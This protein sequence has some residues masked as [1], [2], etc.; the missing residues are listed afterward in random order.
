MMLSEK[1]KEMV[2][3]QDWCYVELPQS[4]TDALQSIGIDL[5]T[6][7][8]TFYLHLADG[9][10]FYSRNEELYQICWF[11]LN[12]DY[13]RSLDMAHQ[14]LK[15]PQEYIPLNAFEGEGG[16]FYNRKT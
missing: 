7:F 15:L 4:Y 12:T 9:S 10:T 11:I 14:S 13:Q 8:A 2:E 16:Y 5:Q 6:T 1:V 3:D